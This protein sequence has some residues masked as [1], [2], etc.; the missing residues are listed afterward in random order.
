MKRQPSVPDCLK[1]DLNDEFASQAAY[2]GRRGAFEYR[3][4]VL[5]GAARAVGARAPTYGLRLARCGL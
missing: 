2:R 1:V 4:R 5:G 3:D